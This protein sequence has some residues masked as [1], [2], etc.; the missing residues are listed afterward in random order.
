ME[1]IFGLVIGLVAGAFVGA[2]HNQRVNTLRDK[3]KDAIAEAQKK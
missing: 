1:F 2:K 3:A